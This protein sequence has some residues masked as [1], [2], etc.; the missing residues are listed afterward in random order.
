MLVSLE[1]PSLELLTASHDEDSK[2]CSCCKI[3][4]KKD[5][6]LQMKYDCDYRDCERWM[7][8]NCATIQELCRHREV[9]TLGTLN[10]LKELQKKE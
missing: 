10:K 2:K 6:G 8:T 4:N 1:R 3:K 9:V 5:K 7:C